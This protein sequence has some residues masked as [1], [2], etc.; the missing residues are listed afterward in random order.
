MSG[1][2]LRAARQPSV[3]IAITVAF[4]EPAH[5]SIPTPASVSKPGIWLP[6]RTGL[7]CWAVR[8]QPRRSAVSYKEAQEFRSIDRGCGLGPGCAVAL[9][10][11]FDPRGAVAAHRSRFRVPEVAPASALQAAPVSLSSVA[12]DCL[13]ER[14]GAR[15]PVWQS[16]P[17]R[18]GCYGWQPA[19]PSA[20]QRGVSNAGHQDALVANDGAHRHKVDRA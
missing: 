6:C 9:T 2:C 20:T 19:G 4:C 18:T 8:Q 3:A 12:I 7:S 17:R 11:C 16:T 13:T 1:H 14:T 5:S 10:V 15:R